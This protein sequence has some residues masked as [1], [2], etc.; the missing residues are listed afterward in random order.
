MLLT[1]ELLFNE[2]YEPFISLR[3]TCSSTW[4]HLIFHKSYFFGIR[5]QLPSPF[6]TEP[7]TFHVS[8]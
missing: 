5:T 2:A 3:R 4:Y 8:C 7:G 6:R 1:D